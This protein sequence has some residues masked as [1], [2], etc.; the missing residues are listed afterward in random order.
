[1]KSPDGHGSSTGEG[2]EGALLLL[3]GGGPTNADNASQRALALPSSNALRP[4]SNLN[5]GWYRPAT[6]DDSQRDGGERDE[7]PVHDEPGQTEEGRSTVAAAEMRLGLHAEP[8]P[9]DLNE[10]PL[11]ARR[12]RSRPAGSSHEARGRETG[13]ARVALA[14]LRRL[15]AVGLDP[16]ARQLRKRPP[17]VGVATVLLVLVA[18]AAVTA[19]DQP[20]GRHRGA[21]H[22]GSGIEAS[23]LQRE[24]LSKVASSLSVLSRSELRA[25]VGTAVQPRSPSDAHRRFEI[26]RA[27]GK[28]RNHT[29][30][31]RISS[32][33]SH[34]T[35]V[36]NTTAATSQSTSDSTPSAGSDSGTT[37]TPEAPA[38][39]TPV[40][41]TPVQ[42]TGTQQPVHY[43]PPAHAAGPA[44]LGSQVGGS[45]SPKCS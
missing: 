32:T 2:R 12:S 11:G 9:C 3:R 7:W 41:Q 16:G 27:R 24:F 25:T 37:T 21:A 15:A 35:P 31:A 30:A 36:S 43:Q 38:Q 18:F 6:P 29:R 33:S 13:R 34:S 17:A 40:Q 19:L 39:T 44:G 5:L 14:R 20:G 4:D 10:S 22:I 1:M 42:Q 8:T 23:D 28:Q 26:A 45:C